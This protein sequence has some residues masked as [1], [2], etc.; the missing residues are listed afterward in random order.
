LAASTVRWTF[1]PTLLTIGGIL[2]LGKPILWLFG[3][4]FDDGYPLMFI[5]AIALVARAAVGPTE[6]V[7]NMLGEQRR[8]AM[9]Y[10]AMFA[11]NLGGSLMVAGPYG[12]MGVAIVI[13][14]A[15]VIESV[16][17][18]MIAKRR[19]GLHMLIWR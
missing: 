3:P 6:R 13:A 16:L 9:V 17:L 14:T 1:W 8:C 11:L 10:A 18:F 19:L 4:S 5:L 15:A 2:A 7:L 12:S